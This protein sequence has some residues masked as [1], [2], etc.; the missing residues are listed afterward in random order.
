MSAA[1]RW[2]RLGG[3]RASPGQGRGGPAGAGGMNLTWLFEGGRR[4]RSFEYSAAGAAQDPAGPR[5]GGLGMGGRGRPGV[6]HG[7]GSAPSTPAAVAEARALPSLS[8]SGLLHP[9][10]P[11]A[12]PRPAPP[13]AGPSGSRL[14]GERS[15]PGGGRSGGRVRARTVQGEGQATGTPVIQSGGFQFREAEEDRWDGDLRD[16]TRDPQAGEGG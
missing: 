2:E 5:G 15:G 12:P 4:R 10:R 13:R 6:D 1:L 8:P 7:R 11:A 14:E 9:P 3:G 16:G